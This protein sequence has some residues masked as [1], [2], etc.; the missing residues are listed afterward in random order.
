MAV[1]AAPLTGSFERV[2]VADGTATVTSW[3]GTDLTRTTLAPGVHMIAHHN[4]DDPRTV[5][6][7]TWLPEF[8]KLAG[9][10]NDWRD[11]WRE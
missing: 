4:V 8:Q 10:G 5:R 7:E 11:E 9:A 6:I 1:P 3:D 2:S